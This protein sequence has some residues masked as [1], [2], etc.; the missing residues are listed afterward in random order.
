MGRFGRIRTSGKQILVADVKGGVRV[1]G[2]HDAVLADNVPRTA[3]LVAKSITDLY[4]PNISPIA[5]PLEIT[6][7]CQKGRFHPREC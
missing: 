7:E 4:A 6:N 3:V 5:L 1:R 2:E